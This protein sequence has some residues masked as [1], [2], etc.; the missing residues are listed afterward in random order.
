MMA[1]T[2]WVC[3][4]IFLRELLMLLLPV[5][6]SFFGSLFVW[7]VS[8]LAGDRPMSPQFWKVHSPPRCLLST[9][10]HNN[11]IVKAVW[12]LDVFS[13]WPICGMQ[14]CASKC[15]VC[16]SERS[17]YLWC[18]IVSHALQSALESR[19]EARI[20]LIDFSA[21]F[22]RVNH[23]GILY[24]LWPVGIGGSVLSIL[25]QFLSNRSHHVMV[26]GCR[27]K[28]VNVVSGVPQGSV[29]GPLLFLLYTSQL[30]S[31]LDNKLSVMLMTPLW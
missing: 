17:G 23:L 13:S 10:F 11:R 5:L 2:H 24:K 9:D 14:W 6:V 8:R 26:D 7:V 18:I 22:D 31:I 1:L 25:T 28:L 12:V 30:F 21:A 15:P 4:L 19:Q 3:F 20:V 16:L 27:S 29:M